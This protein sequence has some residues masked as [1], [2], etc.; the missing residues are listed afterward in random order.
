MFGG[1]LV[2]KRDAHGI[3]LVTAARRALKKVI[4]LD[5]NGGDKKFEQYPHG[6]VSHDEKTYEQP[7]NHGP[8]GEHL[9]YEQRS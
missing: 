6:L 1:N 4:V 9:R 3:P 8:D 7:Y 5:S 2:E